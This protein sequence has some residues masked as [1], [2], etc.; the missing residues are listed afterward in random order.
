MGTA[1]PVIAA[2]N[3]KGVS[4]KNVLKVSEPLSA[5][6]DHFLDVAWQEWIKDLAEADLAWQTALGVME[7]CEANGIHAISFLDDSLY[8]ER[9][10]TLCRRRTAA[11]G[12]SDERPAVIYVKGDVQ[13]LRHTSTVVAIVGTRKPT[14]QGEEDSREFGRYSARNRIPVVSGLASRCDQY[15]HEGCLLENGTAIAV[16][17]HGLDRIHP[18]ANENL[19]ERI[20]DNGGCWISEYPAGTNV[21][22]WMFVARDRL[23]SALSDIVIVIQTGRKGGKQNTLRFAREQGRRIA[24]VVP[25][26]LDWGN[27][28]VAGN[29]AILNND[30]DVIPLREASDLEP[31]ISAVSATGQAAESVAVQI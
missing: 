5:D 6:R 30:S 24:C 2:L 19:A 12:F 29:V 13:A 3:L 23:Q 14:R 27:E 20:L 22:K 7:K 11:G 31:H 26:D 8:P 18:R 25:V 28:V 9:L 1:L 21:K 15:G 4:H 17:A 16:L 10:H